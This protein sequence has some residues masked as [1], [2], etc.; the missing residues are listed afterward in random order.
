MRLRMR[1]ILEIFF[2]ILAIASYSALYFESYDR[3]FLALR[4][5]LDTFYSVFDLFLVTIL[6]GGLAKVY[7]SRERIERLLGGK[8]SLRGCFLG[9]VLGGFVPGGGEIRLP[10][11]RTLLDLGAGIG[12]VTAFA[13]SRAIVVNFP[14]GVAFLGFDVASIQV[15]SIIAGAFLGGLFGEII[16]ERLYGEFRKEHV[17]M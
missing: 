6:A 10:I 9:A 3:F 12:A 4:Y 1:D 16:Y 17:H 15:V 13:M 14:Q 7:L 11:A 8:R 5:F 2:S